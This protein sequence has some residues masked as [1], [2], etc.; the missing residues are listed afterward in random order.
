[1]AQNYIHFDMYHDKG[2]KAV[3]EYGYVDDMDLTISTED[4]QVSVRLQK[5]QVYALLQELKEQVE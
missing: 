3:A 1:M 5:E 2:F 4:K